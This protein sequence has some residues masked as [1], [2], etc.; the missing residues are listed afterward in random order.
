MRVLVI[1]GTAFIGPAV[2]SQLVEAGHQVTAFHRGETP[3]RLPDSVG[4][5][6][7]D[8]RDLF[9]FR[10]E[11]ASLKPDAVIDMV[12]MTEH[13]A[14]TTLDTFD[15]VAGRL[16]VISSQDVYRAFTRFNGVEPGPPDPVPLVEDSP[17][18]EA[19][20][21]FRDAPNQRFEWSRDYEKVMVERVI[22]DEGG[23]PATILRLPAVYGPG[24][25]QHRLFGHARRMA[26]SRPFVLLDEGLASWRWTRGYV[27]NIAAAIVLCAL[28]EQAAGRTY[29]VGEP[30]AVTEAEWIRRIGDAM[31]WEGK[32]AVI[33][34]G[35]M[36]PGMN[37]DQ[38]WNADT[39]RI[40]EELGYEEPVPLDHAIGHTV[41]WELANPPP[42]FGGLEQEYAGEDALIAELRMA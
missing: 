23:M 16:V 29:N 10:S 2:V 17:L 12:C 25:Y 1:G 37:T 11:F 5:I 13:H 38:D 20:Y 18:R 34:G 15:G 31:G 4:E 28:D 36:S 33:G 6:L 26:D 42:G 19:L 7:G 39:G 21:L 27:E 24:D 8:R 14:R 9:S 32:I 30:G 3:G 40:R 35:R 22:N 41:E